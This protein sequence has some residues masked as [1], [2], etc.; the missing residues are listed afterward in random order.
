MD[1]IITLAVFIFIVI[2]FICFI[3]FILSNRD[4]IGKI[5]VKFQFVKLFH[6][7]VDVDKEK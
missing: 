4:F 2:G 5:K 7:E 1:T 6:F 3:V